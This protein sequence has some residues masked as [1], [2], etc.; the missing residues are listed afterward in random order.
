M[1]TANTNQGEWHNTT[2]GEDEFILPV[3]YQNL[4]PIHRTFVENMV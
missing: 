2:C 3:R 1:A 4:V